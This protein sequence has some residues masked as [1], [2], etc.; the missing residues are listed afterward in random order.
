MARVSISGGVVCFW[1]GK[2]SPMGSV[3]GDI[4]SWCANFIINNEVG[5]V[6]ASGDA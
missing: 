3:A 4:N 5:Y 6:C 2:H 1:F